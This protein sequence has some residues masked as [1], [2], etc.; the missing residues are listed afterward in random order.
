M[1]GAVTYETSGHACLDLFAVAGGIRYKRQNEQEK[2]FERAYIEDP[3]LAVKLLFYIRD[4]RGGLGERNTFRTLIRFLAK[5]WRDSA[6]KNVHL[7]AEYGRFDDLMCLM[8]TPAQKETVRVISEQLDIDWKALEERRTGNTQAHI[9]L[10]AKWLPSINTSSSRTRGQA[11][12]LASALG[13]SEREYRLKLSALRGALSLAER[14]L[15]EDRLYKLNYEAVPA[16]ALLKYR[17]AF[18][19]RDGGRFLDYVSDALAGERKVHCDTLYPYEIIRPIMAENGY[20]RFT[21]DDAS[22][23]LELLWD[24]QRG[25]V[26][27]ENSIAV[28]DTSGSMYW[29]RNEKDVLPAL[30]AQ[31]LGLYFAEHCRGTFHNTFITFESRPHLV[32]VKGCTLEQKLRSIS[33]AS[34]GGST[35]LEAVFNLLLR[36]AVESGAPQEDMPSTIYII[37]DMEF[38]AAVSDPE[39]TVYECARNLYERHGY[40]MPAVVFHNV[41]SWQMQTPVRSDTRGTALT[42]GAGARAMQDDF[43]GNITPMDHMLRVLNGPRYEAVHA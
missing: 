12:V 38:N 13:L 31:S 21:H 22:D 17:K 25:T 32:E 29:R 39:Q 34:W 16:G 11:M 9:S 41:N 8:G 37:S 35:D 30:I 3:E 24:S 10:L 15:T 4:I 42:S 23:V 40:K 14:G 7:I 33:S 28:I 43:D 26:G 6:I 20:C 36:T 1:N 5:N 19:K 27:S 2:L 18:R